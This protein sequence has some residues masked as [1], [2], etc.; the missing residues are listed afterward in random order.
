MLPNINLFHL[1]LLI[2]LLFVGDWMTPTPSYRAHPFHRG[3]RVTTVQLYPQHITSL[4]PWWG[5]TWH[6]CTVHFGVLFTSKYAQYI[7]SGYR[8]KNVPYIFWGIHGTLKENVHVHFS[9]IRSSSLKMY[10]V[11]FEVQPKDFREHQGIRWN[12]END[13]IKYYDNGKKDSCIDHHKPR[14]GPHWSHSD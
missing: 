9:G 7:F 12:M 11:H 6:I 1:T 3:G 13:G 14:H 8:W 4:P 5:G 10:M 2:A